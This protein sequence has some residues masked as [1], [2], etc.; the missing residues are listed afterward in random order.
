MGSNSDSIDSSHVD[1]IIGLGPCKHTLV[2][3]WFTKKIISQNVVGLCIAKVLQNPL[4]HK[5]ECIGYMSV[6][7]DYKEKFI[8]KNHRIWAKLHTDTRCV[9]E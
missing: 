6:G 5:E 8:H 4:I 7:I 9:L 2:N 3:Q 1:G